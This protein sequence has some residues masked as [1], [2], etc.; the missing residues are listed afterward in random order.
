MVK[1]KADQERVRA[2]LTDTVVLLCRNGLTFK[3]NLTLQGLIAVTTDDS[4]VFVVQINDIMSLD[5]GVVATDNRPRRRQP[6]DVNSG[7]RI[8]VKEEILPKIGEVQST[9]SFCTG[10][11]GESNVDNKA[12]DCLTQNMASGDNKQNLVPIVVENSHFDVLDK[13]DL[14]EMSSERNILSIKEEDRVEDDD[15]IFVNDSTSQ[16][17]T[18]KVGQYVDISDDGYDDTVNTRRSNA[19]KYEHEQLYQVG[20]AK[21]EEDEEEEEGE[22]QNEESYENEPSHELSNINSE[23]TYETGDDMTY[24]TGP[25]QDEQTNET[26]AVG[27]NTF[28][29]HYEKTNLR[30]IPEHSGTV[31]ILPTGQGLPNKN[32]KRCHSSS[33]STVDQTANQYIDESEYLLNSNVE[34]TENVTGWKINQDAQDWAPAQE[35]AWKP[36]AGQVRALNPGHFTIRKVYY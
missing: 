34:P 24:E 10:A 23:Q 17:D 6:E 12:S 3:R 14:S 28:S 1:L 9:A 16:R 26:G 2:L 25:Y 4:D 29:D 11:S 20:Y 5:A 30:N 13:T 33:Y 27:T 15:V 8:N 21:G 31:Q 35:G 7:H 18:G 32:G 19:E 22:D 36:Y